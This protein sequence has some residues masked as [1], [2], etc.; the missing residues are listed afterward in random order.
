MNG[1]TPIDQV[2]QAVL[3]SAKYRHVCPELVSRIGQKEL[4]A[5]PNLKTAIKETK[6]TLHQIAGAYLDHTPRYADW[7]RDLEVA[8]GPEAL[9]ALCLRWMEQHASTRERLPSLESFYRTVMAEVG[10]VHSVLD[11]AC[12]LNPLALP[13]MGLGREVRYDACDLYGDMMGFVGAFLERIGQT[14][15]AYVCDA[16][17]APPTQKADLALI[18]KFLPV[19]EQTERDSTLAWLQRLQARNLLVSF[20]TRSLGGRGKGMA[21]HY[22]TRFRETIRA[23]GWSVQRFAFPNELCFLVRREGF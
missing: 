3:E 6:N 10:P 23:V 8:E 12:G 9:R 4:A 18:L 14:G 5:R 21:E 16:A 13:W 17:A 7:R 19:L 11:I 20:P 1:N 15:S 2:V 22:E